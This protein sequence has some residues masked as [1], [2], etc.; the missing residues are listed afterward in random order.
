MLRTLLHRTATLTTRRR[1]CEATL[2][3]NRSF[4]CSWTQV[5]GCS[6]SGQYGSGLFFDGGNCDLVSGSWFPRPQDAQRKPS[7]VLERFDRRLDFKHG[8]TNRR[9][10]V[11][12]VG[13]RKQFRLNHAGPVRQGQKFHRLTG[14]LVVRPLFQPA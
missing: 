14:D 1:H 2:I 11:A 8:V 7:S 5:Q 3:W 6:A 10:S 9:Q 13:L 12:F 4:Q